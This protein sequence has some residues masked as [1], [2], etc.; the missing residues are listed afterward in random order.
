MAAAAESSRPGPSLERSGTL[1]ALKHRMST[2]SR[3]DRVEAKYAVVMEFPNLELHSAAAAGNVG[4][5]HYALTHGQ[6][7]NSVMH[8][9][10]PIHAACSGGNMS[11]VRML[12]ENG[13][14]VNAPRLPRRYSDGRKPGAPAVGTAGSTPLHFAAANG[15]ANVVQVLL[16]CGANPDKP[17]KNGMTPEDLADMSGHGDVLRTLR[18]WEHLRLVESQLAT[19]SA[20]PAVADADDATDGSAVAVS[21]GASLH[22]SRKGKERAGS[23]AS[24]HSLTDKLVALKTSLES[25]LHTRQS[26]TELRGPS[27][28]DASGAS[29]SATP[30]SSPFAPSDPASPA[31]DMPGVELGRV[32]THASAGSSVANL[33]DLAPTPPPS[34]P[35]PKSSRRPSL[36]SIFEKATH[37]G[38]AFR[39]VMRRDRQSVSAETSPRQPTPAQ[40]T[41]HG[42]LAPPFFRGRSR[43]LERAAP[44]S[45]P[46]TQTHH[47]TKRYS[48]QSLLHLFKR[49][50]SPPSRSP[51]PPM[52]NDAQRVIGT[53]ELDEGIAKLKRASIDLDR[54]RGPDSEPADV[55]DL[56]DDA[57]ANE[58]DEIAA[59]PVSAISVTSA[60]ATRSRFFE[61]FSTPPA[62]SSASIA[63]S[64]TTSTSTGSTATSTSA[65]SDRTERPP[66]SRAGSGVVSPSPL[67]KE[68]AD[69]PSSDDEQRPTVQRAASHSGHATPGTRSPGA[70]TVRR[71]PS[72]PAT[73]MPVGL[74][75][76][77]DS[78]DL[79]KVASGVLRRES[80]KQREAQTNES[81]DEEDEGKD[82]F[83]DALV[84]EPS[85]PTDEAISDHDTAPPSLSVVSGRMRGASIGSVTTDST[86]ISTPPGSHR[87]VAAHEESERAFDARGTGLGVLP[88][89]PLSAFDTRPRGKST[90][91]VASSASG[92]YPVILASASSTSL[93][94]PS[95]MSVAL[96]SGFPPVP[97][98]EVARA[99][100]PPV[101]HPSTRRV[102][103]RAEARD[104]LEQ[105]ER[106]IMQ[107]AQ[108][109]PSA[110]SSRSLSAQL[111]A[112]GENHALE[113]E[114][115]RI[116]RMSS[117]DRDESAVSAMS[118]V[119]ADDASFI[120]AH[121]G[122]SRRS[123]GSSKRSQKPRAPA[124]AMTPIDA[125]RTAVPA[126][127]NIYDRR[128]AAYRERLAALT[129][130]PPVLPS[131]QPGPF[132]PLPTGSTPFDAWTRP[133]TRSASDSSVS[134]A[135]TAHASPGAR[136]PHISS[137]MPVVSPIHVSPRKPSRSATARHAASSLGTSLK[138]RSSSLSSALPSS[139][140]G[141]YAPRSPGALGTGTLGT[142]TLGA[143]YD[144]AWAPSPSPAPG[145]SADSR[146]S[147][148]GKYAHHFAQSQGD[149]DDSDDE[150]GAR[151][152]YTVIENDWRGGHVVKPELGKRKTGL[153]G[154]V[155]HLRR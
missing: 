115:A 11:V 21:S 145:T 9:V 25:S 50:Q 114:F 117:R 44:A 5:V 144:A 3:A 57:E 129:S 23:F 139:L 146:A 111:A 19:A 34:T 128:A 89:R 125:P 112:Y 94:P 140:P 33:D 53:N 70:S 8:G 65:T 95:I 99:T 102:S 1:E 86:R 93:T 97:E 52:R 75:S 4:L 107:L 47:A 76:W 72:L 113:Q 152:R 48:K 131:A 133:G 63:P 92:V 71:T 73:A 6:P 127:N 22:S 30:L 147:W 155:G 10:L 137:P 36:P 84:E 83:Y 77:V 55:V 17:D 69:S 45:A 14:D 98:N 18:A 41:A 100:S 16:A 90:S 151:R 141:P 39:A 154:V 68:W 121:S 138:V 143:S 51:S 120:T 62:R 7:V 49:G 91:S 130:A 13:A 122:E 15:H 38:A 2:G 108:L 42:H 106:D 148:A 31:Q 24:T 74:G 104:Q 28:F 153:R 78:V 135:E 67:A 59:L 35:H 29:V 126:L 20:V 85:A 79:R 64:T 32:E 109:P 54:Y 88:L 118:K 12:I 103:S 87:S 61:D 119:S 58:I 116:E 124:T 82:E 101:R 105:N 26:L 136:H 110:D 150:A 142:G 96:G 40:Q 123:E 37:P 66:R 134:L 60:P 46:P 27:P 81:E 149:G 80:E 56:G 43:A 132:A